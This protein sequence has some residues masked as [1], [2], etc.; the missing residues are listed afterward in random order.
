MLVVPLVELQVLLTYTCHDITEL[1][2]PPCSTGSTHLPLSIIRCRAP[3]V[4][5]PLRPARPH[6]PL[7]MPPVWFVVFILWWNWYKKKVVY[8]KSIYTYINISIYLYLSLTHSQTYKSVR[9]KRLCRLD[10][11]PPLTLSMWSRPLTNHKTEPRPRPHS[12]YQAAGTLSI[13]KTS[14]F[15]HTTNTHIHVFI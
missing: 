9:D 6:N 13:L 2:P 11:A 3:T 7:K 8:Y 10:L 14:I 15:W 1:T 5:S 12:I 4:L